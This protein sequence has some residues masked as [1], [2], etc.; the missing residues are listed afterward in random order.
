MTEMTEVQTVAHQIT[1]AQEGAIEPAIPILEE[2]AL[3]PYACSSIE[4][5]SGGFVNFTFRGFLSNPLPN[6]S[7]SVI[8]KHSKD[9][10]GF[11]P[12]VQLQADRCVCEQKVSRT[13]CCL[14]FHHL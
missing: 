2:L 13:T 10:L 11:I 1:V 12:G 9:F 8:I 14:T 5:V 4:Q 7:S 3:T 6:G